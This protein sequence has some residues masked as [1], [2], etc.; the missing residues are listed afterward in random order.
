MPLIS[1]EQTRPPSEQLVDLHVYL[2]PT[3]SWNEQYRSVFNQAVNQT[4][5]AGFVRAHPEDHLYKLRD[6]VEEQLGSDIIP[7]EYVFLRSVGRC[8]TQVKGKQELILKVKNFLPP[9]NFSAEI[10]VLKSKREPV[11]LPDINRSK[12]HLL[13]R[14]YSRTEGTQTTQSTNSGYHSDDWSANHVKP[15]STDFSMSNQHSVSVKSQNKKTINPS[16]KNSVRKGPKGVNRKGITTLGGRTQQ[17]GVRIHQGGKI[18]GKHFREMTN[19]RPENRGLATARILEKVSQNSKAGFERESSPNVGTSKIGRGKCQGM[20]SNRNMD[21]NSRL[22]EGEL[23]LGMSTEDRSARVAAGIDRQANHVSLETVKRRMIPQTKEQHGHIAPHSSHQPSNQGDN[24]SSSSHDTHSSFSSSGHPPLPPIATHQYPTPPRSDSP[25]HKHKTKS[26]QYDL[27]S[28]SQDSLPRFL[29]PEQNDHIF[30]T[31]DVEEQS[32]RSQAPT[33]S[34]QDY[35]PPLSATPPDSPLYNVAPTLLTN[36]MEIPEPRKALDKSGWRDTYTNG[37]NEDSGIAEPTPE[38]DLGF[39]QQHHNLLESEVIDQHSD[40]GNMIVLHHNQEEPHRT[41]Q[42]RRF[43]DDDNSSKAIEEKTVHDFQMNYEKFLEDEEN[44]KELENLQLMREQNAQNVADVRRKKEEMQRAMSRRARELASQNSHD[45]KQYQVNEIEPYEGSSFAS[46]EVSQ[47]EDITGHD[48]IEPEHLM[49]EQRDL[50]QESWSDGQ[51]STLTEKELLQ[52]L[53]KNEAEKNRMA[54]EAIQIE[55]SAKEHSF[56]KKGKKKG[57]SS[58]VEKQHQDTPSSAEASAVSSRPGHQTNQPNKNKDCNQLLLDL[59]EMREQRL[60]IE[61][62]REDLV[63]KAKTLQSRTQDRRNKAPFGREGKDGSLTRDY[64]KKQYFEEKKLTNPLEDHINK[65]RQQVEQAHRKLITMMEGR[66][67]AKKIPPSQK[68]NHKI[69]IAKS[70]HDLEDLRRRVENAKMRLT[71]EMKLRNQAEKELRNLKNEL[72]QKKIHVTLTRSQ[73]LAILKE[74][75]ETLLSSRTPQPHRTS[76]PRKTPVVPT[77]ISQSL[78]S[79][80]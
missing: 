59:E 19:R 30:P 74:S 62:R 14:K 76:Q 49:D 7:E 15:K 35:R 65:L 5:S 80:P 44:R 58:V 23:R 13:E 55:D 11:P 47:Y 77:Q 25:S 40:N 46:K 37:T 21:K 16:K 41:E 53:R 33:N 2:V 34:N 4:I 73:Q 39:H 1:A 71:S 70:Q 22:T 50:N 43:H 6:D 27:A 61:Q 69:N 38:E 54:L 24:L 75:E 36:K 42:R 20:S 31:Q 64:W 56:L 52:K 72:T 78:T 48:N 63:R 18:S 68:N 57:I 32:P 26:Q 10:F 28:R 8:L 9:Y 29:S 12:E 45:T 67:Q 51:P 3:S 60:A 66:M 17:G 79:R